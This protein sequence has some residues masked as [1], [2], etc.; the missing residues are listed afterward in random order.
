MRLYKGAALTEQDQNDEQER[1]LKEIEREG[2]VKSL[3]EKAL[4]ILLSLAYIAAIN[5][6]LEWR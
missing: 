1:D 6:I 3:F 4:I 2:K 5:L